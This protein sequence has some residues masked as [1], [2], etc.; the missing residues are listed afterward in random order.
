MTAI[1]NH[2]YIENE[3]DLGIIVEKGV[4]TLS[5]KV[6]SLLEKDQVEDLANEIKGVIAVNNNLQVVEEEA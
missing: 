3:D 2:P 6:S 1:A 4:V 5:G